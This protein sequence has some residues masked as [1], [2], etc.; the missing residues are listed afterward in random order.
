MTSQLVGT[1]FTGGSQLPNYVNGRL[2]TAEDL[3]TSQATLRTRDRRIGQ[4]AGHGVV[5]GLWVTAAATSLTVA[6]GLAVAPS[7]DAVT[8]GASI[9]LPL[10]FAAAA[11]TATGASFSC[12]TPASPGGTAAIS[13]GPYLLTAQPTCQLSGSAPMAAPP[14]STSSAGCAAQ[15][16]VEGVQFKAIPLPMGDTVLDVPVTA[17]NRRTL[18]AH[19]CL[20]TEQLALLGADPFSFAP[21]YGGFDTLD[22]ADL[23][24]SDAPLAVFYW[25]GQAVDFVDNWSARRSITAPD[26]VTAPWSGVVADRRRADGQARFLQFQDQA[27]EIVAAGAAANTS[28]ATTFPLLPPV[29]FLPIG[30]QLVTE[31]LG[32]LRG[33]ILKL[34]ELERQRREQDPAEGAPAGRFDLGDADMFSVTPGGVRFNFVR[35]LTVEQLDYISSALGVK[36]TQPAFDLST[37]FGGS[38]TCGGI[39]DWDVADFALRQSWEAAPGSP[40]SSVFGKTAFGDEDFAALTTQQWTSAGDS[41]AGGG[42]YVAPPIADVGIG[43]LDGQ[44]ATA[45]LIWYLVLQNITAG[46]ASALGAGTTPT[47]YVVFMKNTVWSRGTQPPFV[48]GELFSA[49]AAVSANKR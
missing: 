14:D 48:S 36:S 35:A 46:G 19:W 11:S 31:V 37:F 22:P 33:S 47:L 44:A 9:T 6:P 7:G 28:A 15:W 2:L 17:D 38:A 1:D 18:L 34:T 23:T 20:G 5:D 26:P 3:A 43:H 40:V 30:T 45:P 29:G 24:P 39:L 49:A 8:V 10:T 32:A 13:T 27:A 4:A 41:G 42:V 21:G 25:N 16:Q 12:C